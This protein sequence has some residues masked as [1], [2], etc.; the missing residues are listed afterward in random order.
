MLRSWPRASPQDFPI[1][2]IYAA[3]VNAGRKIVEKGP[4][5]P[6]RK[7]SKTRVIGQ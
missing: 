2:L 1:L 5:R 3:R 7:V 6:S 4:I